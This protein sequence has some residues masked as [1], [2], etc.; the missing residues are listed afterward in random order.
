[1]TTYDLNFV[2]NCSDL[3][4]VDFVAVSS[5]ESDALGNLLVQNEPSSRSVAEVLANNLAVQ[6]LEGYVSSFGCC[7]FG[8]ANDEEEEEPAESSASEESEES[9]E[10]GGADQAKKPKKPK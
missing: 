3:I 1:M 5:F 4:V 9:V 2:N 7:D 8:G 6:L 10:S